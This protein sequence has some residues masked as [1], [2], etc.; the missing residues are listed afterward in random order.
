MH[1]SFL[2]LYNKWFPIYKS[3][4]PADESVGQYSYLYFVELISLTG[5]LYLII[6]ASV[7]AITK[8]RALGTFI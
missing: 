5:N 2:G 7:K 8:C 1:K 3:V 6:L 4:H